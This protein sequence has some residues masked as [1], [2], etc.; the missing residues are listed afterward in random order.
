MQLL[1]TS[2]SVRR[3]ANALDVV[4]SCTLPTCQVNGGFS[5]FPLRVWLCRAALLFLGIAPAHLLQCTC[6]C[7][8]LLVLH[9]SWTPVRG[10]MHDQACRICHDTAQGIRSA[11]FFPLRCGARAPARSPGHSSQLRPYPLWTQPVRGTKDKDSDVSPT[12]GRCV[13]ACLKPGSFLSAVSLSSVKS[14]PI[15]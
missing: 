7:R 15:G 2:F 11:M 12:S 1:S 6:M 8:L 14:W 13:N 3:F 9:A 5:F 10:V 4:L